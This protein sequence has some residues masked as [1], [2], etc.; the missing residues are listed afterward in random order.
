[1]LSELG[2]SFLVDDVED[3]ED[4]SEGHRQARASRSGSPHIISTATTNA[5]V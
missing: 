3:G 5:V 1:M 2:F 4:S